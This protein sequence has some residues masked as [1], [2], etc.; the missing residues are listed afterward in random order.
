[1]TFSLKIKFELELMLSGEKTF[2]LLLKYWI[3]DH[4]HT[5]W[6]K[7]VHNTNSRN[8]TNFSELFC[9]LLPSTRKA[10]TPKH[11]K[12]IIKLLNY[13]ILSTWMSGAHPVL[14]F[15]VFKYNSFKI[16]FKMVTNIFSKYSREN[17]LTFSYA[18]H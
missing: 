8:I 11:K 12:Q 5:W 3:W 4:Q 2:V 1:M 9:M 13:N 18:V 17:Y 14:S 6:L 7:N 16:S 10:N 15:S